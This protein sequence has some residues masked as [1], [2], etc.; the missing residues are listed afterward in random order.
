M[1]AFMCPRREAEGAQMLLNPERSE[2]PDTWRD[3]GGLR[4][5]SYDGGLHPEDFMAFVREHTEIGPTDKSYKLYVHAA[6]DRVRGAGKFYTHHFS[7]DLAL[8]TEFAELF[9]GGR[10]NW[11]Y[12][13]HAYVALYVPREVQP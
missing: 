5:C 9:M 2:T 1:S 12:P 3:E 10:V 8:G 11:G 7:L 4:V 6:D 13:G